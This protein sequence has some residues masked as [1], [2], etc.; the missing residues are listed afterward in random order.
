VPRATVVIPTHNRPHLLGRALDSLAAQTF[1]DFDVVV[2][3]DGGIDVSGVLEPDRG[4]CTRLI[5]HGVNRGRSAALNTGIEAADGDLLA[6]LADDDRFYPHHLDTVVRAWDKLGPGHAVYSHAVQVL[7][8]SDGQVLD[9]KVTGAQDF[10][11]ALLLVTNYICAIAVL[12]PTATLKELQGFDTSFDVLEDWELWLRVAH[13]LSWHHVDV[14]TV[15]YRVREGRDNSTTREFFRFHPALERVYEKHP[16]PSGSPL[17]ANRDEL[18]RGSE[19]RVNAYGF[20]VSVVIAC[21]GGPSEVVPTLRNVVEVL[22]SASY[23]VVLLVPTVD[24]WDELLSNL[25]GDLQTYAVGDADAETAWEWARQRAA[26]RHL[27]LL[28]AGEVL[29]PELVVSV[30][31]QPAGSS[32]RAGRS[33]AVVS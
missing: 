1:T 28:R 31:Q 8:S 29:D 13:R 17:Q 24:G 11:H 7:E 25:K 15:E 27:L 33:P 9:R 18:L 32:L 26:G 23:E 10:N 30:L 6:I 16:L 12:V 21:Q 20:A 19:G 2:V 3:N 5:D 14:P 4:L 22:S